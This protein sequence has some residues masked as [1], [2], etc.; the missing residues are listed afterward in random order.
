M[1]SALVADDD[2]EKTTK[3]PNIKETMDLLGLKYS[4]AGRNKIKRAI[5]TRKKI[6]AAKISTRNAKWIL[7]IKRQWKGSRKVTKAVR[8]KL[9]SG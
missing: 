9:S 2:G 6:K 4:N 5:Q 8:A 3:T 1:L 7:L